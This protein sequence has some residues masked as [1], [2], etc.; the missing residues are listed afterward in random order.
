[1]VQALKLS[2]AHGIAVRHDERWNDDRQALLAESLHFANFAQHAAALRNEQVQAVMGIDIGR[3]H[4][5]HGTRERS[6]QAVGEHGFKHRPFKEPVPFPSARSDFRVALP[7]LRSRRLR[8]VLWAA[9]TCGSDTPLD[10]CA[11]TA[12]GGALT[13]MSG[14]CAICAGNA[15]PS[16]ASAGT[17]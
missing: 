3:D 11:A 9:T 15:K 5:I 8:A 4:A 16:G 10:A 6:I 12:I 13:L 17:E 2:K 14:N 1:M 7:A